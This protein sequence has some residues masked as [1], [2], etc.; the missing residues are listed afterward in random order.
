MYSTNGTPITIYNPYSTVTNADGT[1][2]R[3]A[4]PNNQI[5]SSLLSA[6]AQKVLSYY[7][8]PNNPGVLGPSGEY[9]GIGNYFVPGSQRSSYDRTDIK[10]DNNFGE[11]E[12]V[13]ARFSR[14]NYTINAVDVFNNPIVSPTS[15]STRNNLQPGDNAVLSLTS[16]LSNP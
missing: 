9:T 10:I 1:V 7:P 2:T 15:L 8:K 12:R 5:P 16:L 14:D 6:F 4:F 13:M 11:K 3:A